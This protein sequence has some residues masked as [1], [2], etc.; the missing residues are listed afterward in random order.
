ME[1]IGEIIIEE[2][3][4]CWMNEKYKDNE[5][6]FLCVWFGVCVVWFGS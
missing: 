6:S 5:V 4:E 1:Y 3:C 2:E